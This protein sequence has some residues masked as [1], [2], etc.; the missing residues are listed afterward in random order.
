M[1]DPGP[2]RHA[3][4]EEIRAR[5]LG[6]ICEITRREPAETAGSSDA[7]PCVGGGLLNDSLDVL[8]FV[9]ALQREFGISIRDGE[10]GRHV[11]TDLGTVTRYVLEHRVK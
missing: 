5:L 8:E 11:L 4:H 7:T 3:T 10:V 9:V 2:V 6:M 1:P